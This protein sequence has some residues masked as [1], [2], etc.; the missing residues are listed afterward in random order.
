VVSISV[1][2]EAATSVVIFSYAV[3][4]F[5]EEYAA[6]IL[7]SEDRG[8]ILLENLLLITRREFTVALL[9]RPQSE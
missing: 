1:S 2:D 6:S 7:Y 9:T 4:K 3:T 5:S 8:R